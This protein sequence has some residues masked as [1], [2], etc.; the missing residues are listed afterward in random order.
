[1]PFRVSANSLY[2]LTPTAPQAGDVIQVWYWTAHI[3]TEAVC[4]VTPEDQAIIILGATAYAG[5]ESERHASG[6]FTQPDSTGKDIK[7]W[8][9]PEI[10]AS[11][12]PSWDKRQERAMAPANI[13][14]W[15]TSSV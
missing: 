4:T 2:L 11:I 14:Q 12:A 13:I 6:N 10:A 5:L 1:V 3:V 8:A 15:D 7:A 9:S